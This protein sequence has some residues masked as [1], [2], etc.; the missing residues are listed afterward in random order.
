VG[1]SRRAHNRDEWMP[2]P[3]I[4]GENS[5]IVVDDA[6]RHLTLRAG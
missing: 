1:L 3:T 2:G 4:P 5:P 6:R